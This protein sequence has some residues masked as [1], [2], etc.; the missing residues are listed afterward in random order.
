MPWLCRVSLRGSAEH[1]DKPP[2]MTHECCRGTQ[3]M[4]QERTKSP[5]LHWQSRRFHQQAEQ[6]WGQLLN[7]K[8]LQGFLLQWFCDFLSLSVQGLQS[9]IIVACYPREAESRISCPRFFCLQ[10][11]IIKSIPVRQVETELYPS[12]WLFP[13]QFWLSAYSVSSCLDYL[14]KKRSL[15]SKSHFILYSKRIRWVSFNSSD[16][17]E[18]VYVYAKSVG[19]SHKQHLYFLNCFQ[20]FLIHLPRYPNAFLFLKIFVGIFYFLLPEAVHWQVEKQSRN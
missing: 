5:P 3:R 4:H 10:M 8:F 6:Y 7:P 19:L 9:E 11:K 12:T 18:S 16:I 17:L 1:P 14:N 15:V 2:L 13:T 20:P